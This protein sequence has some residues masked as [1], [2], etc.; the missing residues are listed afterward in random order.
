MQT[1]V[2]RI[3]L[4]TADQLDDAIRNLCTV[5]GGANYKLAATFTQG[6]Q[7]ILIFQK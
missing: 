4:S 5:R 6:P 2:D 3:N 1:I 7:L